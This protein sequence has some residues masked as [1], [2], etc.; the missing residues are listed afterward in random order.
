MADDELPGGAGGG[1]TTERLHDPNPERYRY[2]ADIFYRFANNKISIADIAQL[3]R[4]SIQKLA[5]VGHMKYQYGRLDDALEIFQTL[6]KVDATNYYFR[7]ALGG[8]YQK[9]KKWVDAVASYSMSL[10][11][12]PKDSA[13]LV[14]RGEIYLRHEKFKKAAEDFRSAITL[15]PEGRNLW[16]NRSRSLVI[17]LKRS[18]EAKKAAQAAAALTA[19]KPRQAVAPPQEK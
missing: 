19:K 5:E 11:L 17:A 12:N 16:A 13:S 15:D 14:N 7:S 4:R 1:A 8:V 10:T 6:A 18:L 3:P 9:L 2:L